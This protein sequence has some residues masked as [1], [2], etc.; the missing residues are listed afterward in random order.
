MEKIALVTDSTCDVSPAELEQWGVRCVNLKVYRSDG[1]QFPDGNTPEN[2]EAFFTYLDRCDQLPHTSMPSP[3]EFGEVYSQLASEGYTHVLS[4]HLPLAMSGTSTAAMMAAQSAP[5]EVAVVDT[6]RNTWALGLLVRRLARM[7]DANQPFSQLV[8]SARTLYKS[9]DI[10]FALDTLDNL[11]KGGRVGKATGL[12]AS[13][14]DI[15][16]LLTVSDD[17]DVTQL[18]MARS[19]K[20]ATAKLADIAAARVGELGP[21]EG[22][23]VHA[24]NL[25]GA[26]RLRALF[27]ERGIDFKDLGTRQIGPVIAT[28]VATGC[29]GFAYIAQED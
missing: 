3:V 9:C 1:S 20:R 18:G 4:V 6:R 21:L 27:Q 19:M 29:V 7:R 14:L 17:G 28:H 23:F 8:E 10:C 16:P 2:A 12:A 15:K 13:F 5:I 26:E 25:P 22:V 11:V 24:R